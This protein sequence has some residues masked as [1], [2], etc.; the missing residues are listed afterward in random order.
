MSAAPL[1]PTS[2]R[3]AE[4]AA[5]LTQVFAEVRLAIAARQSKPPKPGTPAP[6][7]PPRPRP[8]PKPSQPAKSARRRVA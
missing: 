4:L 3:G 5:E 1:D 2:T 8:T 6:G 7:G